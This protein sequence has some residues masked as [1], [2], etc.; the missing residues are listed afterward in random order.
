MT[1]AG[2]YQGSTLSVT[3]NTDYDAYQRPCRRFD[4]EAGNTL[5][6]YDAASQTT[7]EAKGQG[8]TACTATAPAGA[9]LFKSRKN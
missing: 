5:W 3:R 8:S 1:Q 7:W 2:L 6:G 4:P 9:T